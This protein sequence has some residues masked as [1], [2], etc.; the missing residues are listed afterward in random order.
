MAV[1]EST[2]V[3][4][5]QTEIAKFKAVIESAD[6]RAQLKDALPKHL[7][8]ER[9]AR[10]AWTT[11][12]QTPA[13]RECSSASIAMAVIEAAQLG[14]EPSNVLGHAYLVPYQN[15]HTKRQEAQLILGYKGKME[16]ARR[17]KEVIWITAEVVYEKDHFK[18]R[19]GLHPDIDHVPYEGDEPGEIR[20]AYAVAG[21]RG[22]ER[23]VFVVLTKRDI[24]RR[25]SAS[26]SAGSKFSPWTVWPDAMSRK[27]AVHALA[28]YLPL[29]PEIQTVF[30][31][32][33]KRDMGI[34]RGDEFMV[35]DGEV[36]DV[37]SEGRET[38]D[39]IGSDERIDYSDGELP[40]D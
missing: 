39:D 1:V 23:P 35:S 13:L 4:K 27:S 12:R 18:Y 31:K 24:E 26:K 25:K 34:I 11:V 19:K 14:L 3:D 30:E 33:E 40:L 28:T 22:C 32:D 38:L 20:Y 6:F 29:S 36:I 21:L 37:E 5:P 2:A 8:P 16:L 17:S 9:L 7:T 15:K 10:I